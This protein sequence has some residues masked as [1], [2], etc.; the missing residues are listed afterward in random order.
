MGNNNVKALKSGVWYTAANFI[1]KSIGFVTTPIFTRLLTKQEFGAYSNFMSW[2]AILSII[3]T[4][5]LESTFIRARFE[6]EDSFDE[7]ISSV[8]ALSSVSCAV[9]ILV[10][11]LSARVTLPLMH[12][13]ACYMNGL[14]LYLFFLPAIHMYQAKE[15]YYFHYKASVLISLLIAGGTAFLSVLLVVCM[16]N[17]LNGRVIGTVLPVILTGCALYVL[18]FYKGRRV[19]LPHWKYALAFCLPF[20]PHLLSLNLL[21]TMDR[22]MITD[23]CGETDTALYTLA[24]HCGLIITLLLTSMNSAFAPWVGEK[25]Q[26]GEHEEIRAFSRKYIVLFLLFA[27][28]VMLAAPEILFILGGRSYMEALYVMPPVAMGCVCQF[29][30]VLFVNV[31]QFS[32]KTTGMALASMSAALL[33]YLLNAVFIRRFG[34]M[35]AAYTTLAGYLWLL[36]AHMYLVHRLGFGDIYDYPFVGRAAAVMMAVTVLVNGLYGRTFL[37]YALIMVY[38]V[39]MVRLLLKNKTTILSVLK[40]RSG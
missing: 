14:M 28:G 2:V 6:F 4:L 34:Y 1:S 22:V 7:Y 16:D 12:M 5:N 33:N 18:I 19:V 8:L 15:R 39:F 20:I 29:L 30:Y 17:K 38:L 3:V 10:M 37:R 25:L 32:K 31:E 40:K 27:V 13:N 11:N 21:N 36:L 9:W 23:L 26:S 35:A 24:Y